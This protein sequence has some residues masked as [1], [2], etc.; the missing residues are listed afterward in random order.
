[1]FC[2]IRLR[3]GVV[4][5]VESPESTRRG[6]GAGPSARASP[7]GLKSSSTCS[8]PCGRTPCEASIRFDTMWRVSAEDGMLRRHDDYIAECGIAPTPPLMIHFN[9]PSKWTI[10]MEQEMRAWI[11][12]TYPLT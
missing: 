1:M 3:P 2:P 8:V 6:G 11:K 5:G 4:T 9:G 12:S 7:R 10:T